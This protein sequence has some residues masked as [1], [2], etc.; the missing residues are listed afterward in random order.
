MIASILLCTYDLLV[1]F[2]LSR[3]CPDA[4]GVDDDP[5]VELLVFITNDLQRVTSIVGT[6]THK[7]EDLIY[8]K[9]G[10]LL[11]LTLVFL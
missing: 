5:V 1:E 6:V 8:G 9:G 7:Q 11:T 3:T 10:K 2:L 4:E